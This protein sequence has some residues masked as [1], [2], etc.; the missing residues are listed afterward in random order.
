MHLAKSGSSGVHPREM[1]LPLRS[2]PG[3]CRIAQ[4]PVSL[5]NAQCFSHHI[6]PSPRGFC[7]VPTTMGE[8]DP[9]RLGSLAQVSSRH[10]HPLDPL[11]H[12]HAYV[13]VLHCRPASAS[14]GT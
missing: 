8:C 6:P 3:P 11:L 1:A 5:H 14:S 2:L 7:S 12:T 13:H 9:P 4:I 10:T